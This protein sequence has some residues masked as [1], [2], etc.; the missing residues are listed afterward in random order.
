L[1]FNAHVRNRSALQVFAA[2]AVGL[3]AI[4]VIPFHV[5]VHDGLSI[6]YLLGFNNRAAL[7]LF[8]IFT[9]SFALWTRG[10]GLRLPS[11]S[12]EPGCSFLRAGQVAIACSILGGILV[13]LFSIPQFGLLV[14]A[15][16]QWRTV[17]T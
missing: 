16:C 3:S 17:I 13:W 9:L 7:L 8:L 14:S 12:E 6:S 11:A 4:Y 2:L 5:P 1:T 10:L 15:I